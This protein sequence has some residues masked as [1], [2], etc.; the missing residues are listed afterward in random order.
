MAVTVSA[1]NVADRLDSLAALLTESAKN[2]RDGSGA[3]P[4]QHAKLVEMVE[5]PDFTERVLGGGSI[6]GFSDIYFG[7][8][9]MG[10]CLDA[11]RKHQQDTFMSTAN[12]NLRRI[13]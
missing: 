4:Q 10:E 11:V 2:L 1:P 5:D 12:S 8:L 9:I 7:E 13:Q 3:S 6:E